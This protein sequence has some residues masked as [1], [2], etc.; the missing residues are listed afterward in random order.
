M[1]FGILVVSWMALG[2]LR[3]GVAEWEMGD[4]REKIKNGSA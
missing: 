3:E 1:K 4:D 2:G